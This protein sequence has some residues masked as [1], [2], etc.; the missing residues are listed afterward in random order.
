M[1]DMTTPDEPAASQPTVEP[2]P[3]PAVIETKRGYDQETGAFYG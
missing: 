2:E 3:T 1:A